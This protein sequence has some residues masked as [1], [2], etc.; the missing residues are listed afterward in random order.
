MKDQ[1]NQLP[2]SGTPELVFRMAVKNGRVSVTT[3]VCRDCL[4]TMVTRTPDGPP[5][6]LRRISILAPLRHVACLRPLGAV[7]YLEL[8]GLS[9]L[10][11]PESVTLNSR[12]M[13]ESISTGIALDEPITLRVVEPFDLASDTYRCLS[14]RGSMRQERRVDNLAGQT[15]RSCFGAQQKKTATATLLGA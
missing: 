1:A 13:N 9:L 7:D 14:Y 6:S 10:E 5:V 11:G 4:I 12:K 2:L 15:A 8:N 3:E